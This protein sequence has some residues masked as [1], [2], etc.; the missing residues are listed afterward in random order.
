MHT[1]ER[2]PRH[3]LLLVFFSRRLIVSPESGMGHAAGV[4]IVRA[5]WGADTGSDQ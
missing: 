5:D 4:D 3:G 2:G 1:F